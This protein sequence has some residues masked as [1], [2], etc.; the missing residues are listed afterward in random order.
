MKNINSE[1]GDGMMAKSGK[2]FVVLAKSGTSVDMMEVGC[3]EGPSPSN[4][5]MADASVLNLKQARSPLM[6]AQLQETHGPVAPGPLRASFGHP[7]SGL[8]TPL[9]G[10][11]SSKSI[12]PMASSLLAVGDVASTTGKLILP[13]SLPARSSSSTDGEFLLSSMVDGSSSS[14]PASGDG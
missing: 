2:Q 5:Y 11:S 7:G 4:H 1:S 12:V 3:K 9:P 10:S 6:L 13:L 14:R 8:S